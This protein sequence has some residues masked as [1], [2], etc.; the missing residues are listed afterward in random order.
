MTPPKYATFLRDRMPNMET[1]LIEDGTHL[2]F[3]EYPDQVNAAIQRF[4][5]KLG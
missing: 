3:G 5:E 2:V 1:T 4:L